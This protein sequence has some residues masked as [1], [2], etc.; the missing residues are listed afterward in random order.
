MPDELSQPRRLEPADPRAIAAMLATPFEVE[1]VRFKA[2][3]VTKDKKRAMAVPYV[4]ARAMM[5]RLDA[6]VGI[7]RWQTAYAELAAGGVECRLSL[8][9][10]GDWVTKADAG[11][12]A[13]QSESG[14]RVKSAYSD[15][16]KRAALAWG[17]AR[18]LHRVSGQWVDYDPD[19]KQIT[20]KPTLPAWA[21]PP[22]SASPPSPPPPVTP[23]DKAAAIAGSVPG[24]V[25]GSQ[26]SAT[27]P[28]TGA[29]LLRRMREYDAKLAA[30]AGN[31]TAGGLV[32][33]VVAV[34]VKAGH[35]PD[36]TAWGPPAIALAVETV[37]AFDEARKSGKPGRGPT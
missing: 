8:F 28:A 2:Q 23:R 9:F 32:N 24:V 4:D 15:A 17:I 34:G 25:T 36:V 22:R 26:I 29:E 5:D 3:V 11:S 31:A 30:E 12:P 1:V 14:D 35:G 10:D 19:K 27:V 13:E 21:L 16:F 20:G 6:V 37:R 18:Y 7:E 33:H